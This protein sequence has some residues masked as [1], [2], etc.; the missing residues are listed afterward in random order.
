MFCRMPARQKKGSEVQSDV[1]NTTDTL[2]CC[3]SAADQFE[4]AVSVSAGDRCSISGV[5]DNVVAAAGNAL[6]VKGRNR[7][8][9]AGHG[10]GESRVY[11]AHR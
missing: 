8:G 7:T 5:C 2:S 3:D 1:G 9:F 6:A 4:G 10:N 11:R